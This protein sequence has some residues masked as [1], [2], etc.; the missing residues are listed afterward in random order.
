MVHLWY[1]FASIGTT[2]VAKKST[3]NVPQTYHK[4]TTKV[5]KLL[6]LLLRQIRLHRKIK[7]KQKAPQCATLNAKHSFMK[8]VNSQIMKIGKPLWNH[9]WF[10]ISC[11]SKFCNHQNTKISLWNYALG[12]FGS[13]L[14]AVSTRYPETDTPET[15]TPR[16]ACP[17][18]WYREYED[19]CP[20][21]AF[22][23][24]TRQAV[25]LRG[26]SGQVSFEPVQQ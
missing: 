8:R 7:L 4:C 24:W 12:A 25:T 10:C 1:V 20:G 19:R 18:V 17:E 21:K 23:V 5:L 26:G 11:E 22:N 3:T 15:D 2:S 13:V 14:R 9:S 16:S 6:K